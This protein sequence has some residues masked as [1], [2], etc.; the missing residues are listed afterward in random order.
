[1]REFE[2]PTAPK[3]DRIVSV[4]ILRGFNIFWILGGDGMIWA[5]AEMSRGKGP[6]VEAVGS[7]LGN[8]LTHAAWDGFRFYDFIFPLFIFLTGVSLVISLTHLVEREGKMKAHA[9]VLR[10]ALLLYS[11]G[12]IYYGEVNHHWNDIRFLVVLQRLALCYLFASLR[13]RPVMRCC[14][15][16]QPDQTWSESAE[17]CSHVRSAKLTTKPDHTILID[18]INLKD[19]LCEINT[20]C[21]NLHGGRLLPVGACRRPHFGTS[22]VGAGAVHPIRSV[23]A[24]IVQRL[25]DDVPE[26]PESVQRRNWR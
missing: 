19:V 25:Q 4:D 8:Q 18:A 11:L 3:S 2:A 26:T 21:R 17:E 12:L 14:A 24:A 6:V 16:L 23:S 13:P 7:L 22:M 10:R 1:M 15:G 5:L 9:R 20:D